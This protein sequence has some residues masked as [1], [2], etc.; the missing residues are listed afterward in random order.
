V[1]VRIVDESGEDYLYSKKQ[2]VLIEVPA[3]GEGFNPQIC[4][5]V[6]SGESA[7]SHGRHETARSSNGCLTDYAKL[8]GIRRD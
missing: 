7:Y 3:N 8:V 5:R 4:G 6:A 1:D 2:F